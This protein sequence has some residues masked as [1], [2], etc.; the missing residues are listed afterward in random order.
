MEL[1]TLREEA[2]VQREKRK[3]YIKRIFLRGM[4]LKINVVRKKF[5]S[6]RKE[7]FLFQSQQGKFKSLY[8]TSRLVKPKKLNVWWMEGF[9]QDETPYISHE[10]KLRKFFFRRYSG[11]K[12]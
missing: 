12:M 10:R 8:K 4:P 11:R 9:V 6:A 3:A 7:V 5:R 1:R 2:V